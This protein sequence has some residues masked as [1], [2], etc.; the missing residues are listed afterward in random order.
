MY[1]FDNASG[2]EPSGK[3]FDSE[4]IFVGLSLEI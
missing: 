4:I 3:L 1:F 2:H